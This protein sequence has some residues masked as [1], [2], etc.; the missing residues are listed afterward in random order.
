MG[1][2]E[3]LER[4]GFRPSDERR[5]GRRA[6]SMYVADPNPYL[7]YMVHVYDD[8]TALFIWEFAIAEYLATIGL[9]LGSDEVLNLFLY[10]REDLRGPQDGAWLA[11][12]IDRTERTLASVRL[13][14]PD[15]GGSV[16]AR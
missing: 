6:G 1:F 8:G 9:Q 10:P 15:A 16:A 5:V 14:E 2:V 7:A 13:D 3:A 12:A 4:L 11:D